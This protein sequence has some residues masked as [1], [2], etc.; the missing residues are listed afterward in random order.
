MLYFCSH[1]KSKRKF[2]KLRIAIT[3]L[4]LSVTALHAQKT[5]TVSGVVTDSVSQEKLFYVA[6]AITQNDSV[7]TLVSYAMTDPDGH[8]SI[9]DVP[10]GNYELRLSYATFGTQTQPLA[11]GG[12]NPNIDL[13]TVLVKTNASMLQ[14]V[15]VTA[16]K[17]VFAVDGEKMLYNVAED[18]TIQGGTAADAL[19][20]A[21]GVEVDIEGNIT[22]RGVSSVEIWINDKPSH[23]EAENLKTYIQQLPANSIEK[24]EVIANPSARYSAKGTGGIINIVANSVVKKNSFLSFGVNGSTRPNVSPWL[25]YVYSNEK[26]SFNLYSNFSWYGWKMTNSETKIA[27]NNMGDTSFVYTS[28]SKYLSNQFSGS[29][30]MNGS[31]EFDS[32]NNISFWGGGWVGQGKDK[33]NIDDQTRRE[34]ITNPASYEYSD[35]ATDKNM[36][37]GFNMGAW[38]EHKFNSDGHK[39]TTDVYLGMNPYRGKETNQREY[40]TNNM[41]NKGIKSNTIHYSLWTSAEVDYTVPYHKNGEISLGVEGSFNNVNTNYLKDTLQTDTYVCDELRSLQR[42]AK[43]GGIETYF[44]LQHK[45]GGFTMKYGLRYEWEHLNGIV[46]NQQ[47][48][49]NL[50]K[51]YAKNTFYPSVHLSYKTKSMHN[52]TLSYTR[53]V[54]NPEVRN[55]TS[56]IS[57]GEDSYITGNPD[58]L[59]TFSNSLNAGWTKFFEKFGSVGLTSYFRHSDNEVNQLSDV[60]YSPIFGRYVSFSYP[61]NS[62]TSM[63]AGGEA[64]ITYRLKAFMQIRFYANAYYSY[65]ATHFQAT[66]LRPQQDITNEYFAYSF[67][68][69]FWAK[70]WKVLEV[71]ASANYRSPTK[72]IYTTNKPTYSIDCGL[73]ADF[74]KRKLSVFLDVTDIFNWNKQEYNINSPYLIV[75]S[76]RKYTSRTIRAGITVRLGK[77]ELE[78]KAQQGQGQGQGGGQENGGGQ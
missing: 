65:Q 72:S 8:F 2:M 73:R 66:A 59:Q 27:K 42:I 68:L 62:G 61:V 74:L 35:I 22:L 32:M 18:P 17:P 48:E 25:S 57:Y 5:Y 41:P 56:F 38:Y 43:S 30:W 47:Q 1:K 67:R 14:S 58:L 16:S 49:Y 76:T 71:N 64:N 3:A 21:P 11:I 37:S 9:G 13:G 20:N 6:V 33:Y 78:A 40:E 10:A 46:I 54:S 55:L 50:V 52:F 44:T 63:S 29:L 23:L 45:F 34:Y 19:Q 39:I 4:L 51:D 36:W 53:R 77:M 7:H 15:S 75:H 12:D 60:A 28:N 24:I 31:Y 69:N 26:F 70:L